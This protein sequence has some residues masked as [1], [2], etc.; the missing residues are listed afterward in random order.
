MYACI[1]PLT[2]AG[3][4]V[5]LVG[6]VAS[7]DDVGTDYCPLCSESFAVTVSSSRHIVGQ[8]D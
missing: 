5:L 2:R 7:S 4:R 6:R 8:I 1:H 3:Q